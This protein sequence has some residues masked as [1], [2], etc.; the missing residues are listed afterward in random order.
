MHTDGLRSADALTVSLR[1]I[2]PLRELTGDPAY[3][4]LAELLLSARACHRTRGTG[5]RLRH[6]RG[7]PARRSEAP[8]AG[9]ARPGRRRTL[10][11]ARRG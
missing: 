11:T 4:R 10:P 5:G 2:E 9:A 7:R 8:G 3:E 1:S 6:L